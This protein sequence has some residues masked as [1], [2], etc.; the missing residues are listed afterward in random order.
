MIVR[1]YEED[2]ITVHKLPLYMMGAVAVF[3]VALTSA[4]S[5]GFVDRTAIAHDV[6][7]AEGVTSVSQRSLKFYDEADGSVRV[8]DASTRD[9][10]AR[11]GVGYGG[12]VRS[13]LRSLVHERR[14]RGIGAAT[15]FDLIEWSDGSLSLQDSTTNESIELGSF[16][17]DNR[18]VFA[19]MLKEET[20]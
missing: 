19:A 14:I 12:F 5:L 13:T 3:C 15:P 20:R 11:F 2:E 1:E 8:E 4:V 16:G 17:P 10:V 9:E 18:A 6:R 7:A